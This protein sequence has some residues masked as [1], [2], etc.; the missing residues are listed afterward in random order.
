MIRIS[1]PIPANKIRLVLFDLDG[2]L[3]DSERDLAGAVNA[4]LVKYGRK[5]LPIDVIGTYI[6]DGAPMLV[7]RAL[8]DPSDREFLQEAL[9]YFL[10]YYREHKLDSTRCYDGI[11]EALREIAASDGLV[12]KLAV[13]TNKPVRVSRDIIAGLGIADSFVQIYGG[14]SFETKKPDPQGANTLMR[15]AGAAPEET[16][17]V[18]DSQVDVLTARNAGM[19]SIG[20]TYGFA[21]R[22]LEL[23]VPDVLVDTP[24]EM[25]MALSGEAWAGGK[26]HA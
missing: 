17:M 18:G 16:V 8:G 20:V 6:G 5:E 11:A 15:E 26:P 2:T 25:A 23:V 21:P 1:R 22:T 19:W 14:N 10:L 9:N 24:A 13:L 3:I 12:R 4:M 7:R